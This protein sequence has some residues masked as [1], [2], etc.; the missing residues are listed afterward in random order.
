[1]RAGF[2]GGYMT[3]MGIGMF[4][5][6]LLGIVI[7]VLL[8]IILVK[9]SKLTGTKLTGTKAALGKIADV[10]ASS[11]ALDIIKERFAKGEITEEEYNHMKELLK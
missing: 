11:Q 9:L 6:C 8:V 10:Q 2:G 4:P 5:I 1:M 7:V 3:R